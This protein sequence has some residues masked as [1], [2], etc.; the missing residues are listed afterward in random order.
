MKLDT[1]RFANALALSQL[2]LYV[3]CA[4]LSYVTPGSVI[5]VG[6]NLPH[7][8]DITPLVPAKPLAFELGGFLLGMLGWAVLTW[9]A[10]L[11]LSAIYNGL[12]ARTSDKVAA[13]S[14]LTTAPR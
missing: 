13:R 1:F 3:A 8:L 4:L 12:P 9:V 2:V 11:L 6:K 10:G 5:A 7:A 14:T